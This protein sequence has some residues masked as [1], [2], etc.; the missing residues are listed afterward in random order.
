MAS[1][2]YLNT[3]FGTNVYF[4]V[5]L[6]AFTLRMKFCFVS[7]AAAIAE[8]LFALF[9]M[10]T[11][12]D[13]IYNILFQLTVGSIAIAWT[14]RIYIKKFPLCKLSLMATFFSSLFTAK[15]DC[16][17]GVEKWEKAL[18]NKVAKQYH[19]TK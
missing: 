8:L 11:K 9:Y 6:L 15:G 2:F 16:K 1:A 12:K 7:R 17:E 13:D 18:H 10:I 4:A 14:F 3:F 19:D 5:F